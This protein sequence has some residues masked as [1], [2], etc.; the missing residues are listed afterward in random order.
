M[1]LSVNCE[2]Q[3]FQR[4]DTFLTTSQNMF[5]FFKLFGDDR[6]KTRGY[7]EFQDF[8]SGDVIKEKYYIFKTNNYNLSNLVMTQDEISSIAH[9]NQEKELSV[10]VD[11]NYY[12]PAAKKYHYKKFIE[13]F[14]EI[15]PDDIVALDTKSMKYYLGDFNA[16]INVVFTDKLLKRF[17]AED[18]ISKMFCKTY[19]DFAQLDID[20]KSCLNSRNSEIRRFLR[21]YE[22]AQEAYVSLMNYD[23]E[24]MKYRHLKRISKFFYDKKFK[25][26]VVKY[27]TR[28]SDKDYYKR[29]VE[30]SSSQSAF[31]GDIDVIKESDFYKGKA[32]KFELLDTELVGDD[33][34]DMVNPFVYS[35]VNFVLI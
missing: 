17:F 16:K 33:I 23:I 8:F 13:K 2:D 7:T 10:A 1:K 15:L 22:R 26:S 27:L 25:T 11:I 19:V 35:N 9:I 31:A 3:I 5:N 30:I 4:R 32:D 28:I 20:K 6:I 18:F 29:D 24:F 21:K 34:L 12:Q 14:Q